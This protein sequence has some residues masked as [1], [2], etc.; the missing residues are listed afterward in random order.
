LAS[1]T[2]EL[3]AY[4]QAQAARSVNGRAVAPSTPGNSLIES[5]RDTG[6]RAMGMS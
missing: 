5:I 3:K 2:W 1:W 4:W 6:S